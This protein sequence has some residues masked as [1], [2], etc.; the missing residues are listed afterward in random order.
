ML[1]FYF[2]GKVVHDDHGDGSS[3]EG[4]VVGDVFSVLTLQKCP[5]SHKGQDSMEQSQISK[6]IE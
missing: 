2:I 1:W 4:M 3:A 5:A 6:L